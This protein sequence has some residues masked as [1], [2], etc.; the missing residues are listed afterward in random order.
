MEYIEYKEGILVCG[1]NRASEQLENVVFVLSAASGKD[2][3]ETCDL[4]NQFLQSFEDTLANEADALRE[5]AEAFTEVLEDICESC[6]SRRTRHGSSRTAEKPRRAIANIK[7][8]EKYR[9]P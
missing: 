2:I 1:G 4:I 7:W 9:P 6:R 5:L 3:K 8:S